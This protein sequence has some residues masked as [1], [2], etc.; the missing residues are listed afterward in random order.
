MA[1]RALALLGGQTAVDAASVDA[2][3]GEFT[4]G[5]LIPDWAKEAVA[6]CIR[7]GIIDGQDQALVPDGALTRAQAAAIAARL[8]QKVPVGKL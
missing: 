6:L 1:G 3:L 5:A 2:I 7:E 4:D 8:N